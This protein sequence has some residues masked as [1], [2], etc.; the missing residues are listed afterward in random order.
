MVGRTQEQ[1]SRRRVGE[2][3]DAVRIKLIYSNF[4]GHVI[5]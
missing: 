1:Q 3:D 4:N 2:I 5:R